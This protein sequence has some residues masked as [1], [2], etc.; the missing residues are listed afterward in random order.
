MGDAD[1]SFFNASHS[2]PKSKAFRGSKDLFGGVETLDDC[3]INTC[4]SFVAHDASKIR[5]RGGSLLRSSNV[6]KQTWSENDPEAFVP[7]GDLDISKHEVDVEMYVAYVILRALTGA[8]GNVT[9]HRLHPILVKKDSDAIDGRGRSPDPVFSATDEAYLQVIDDEIARTFENNEHESANAS[10]E[11]TSDERC[12]SVLSMTESDS[13]DMF[14]MAA[15]HFLNSSLPE[16]EDQV[17]TSSDKPP[18][19]QYEFEVDCESG[20]VC[21]RQCVNATQPCVEDGPADASDDTSECNFEYDDDNNSSLAIEEV[22]NANVTEG[23]THSFVELPPDVESDFEVIIDDETCETVYDV[24]DSPALIATKA[25]TFRSR[26][27]TK[28]PRTIRRNTDSSHRRCYSVNDTECYKYREISSDDSSHLP[29]TFDR[30]YTLPSPPRTSLTDTCDRDNSS[31]HGKMRGVPTLSF[32]RCNDDFEERQVSRGSAKSSTPKATN[33]ETP[34]H[35][36]EPKQMCGDTNDQGKD[37]SLPDDSATSDV[38]LNPM[39]QISLNSNERRVKSLSVSIQPGCGNFSTSTTPSCTDELRTRL[40]PDKVDEAI[41]VDV[42]EL[43]SSF[44][45]LPRRHITKVSG[46]ERLS[47]DTRTSDTPDGPPYYKLDKIDETRDEEVNIFEH[48]R[49]RCGRLSYREANELMTDLDRQNELM[50][51]M[52]NDTHRVQDEYLDLRRL[53]L[54]LTHKLDAMTSES[55]PTH[56]TL[57]DDKEK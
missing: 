50:S 14:E 24:V 12:Q 22:L 18:P 4:C 35:D 39:H 8:E 52:I 28:L 43:S 46:D 23:T 15:E 5:R 17:S 27:P 25:S 26:S 56:R 29:D 21:S 49:R 9:N 2:E 36:S 7:A 51:R 10:P 6:Q 31:F 1:A 30:I 11:I 3:S 44:Q 33:T 54:D 55:G 38:N 32:N 57:N 16:E 37:W 45:Q 19:Y 47:Q 20:M 53:V 13:N 41:Q 40:T 34:H 42:G 48:I